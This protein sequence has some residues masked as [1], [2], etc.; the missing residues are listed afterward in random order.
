MTPTQFAH[1]IYQLEL[2][3]INKIIRPLMYHKVS[4]E[5]S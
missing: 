4:Y 1:K 2:Q 3:T 5:R